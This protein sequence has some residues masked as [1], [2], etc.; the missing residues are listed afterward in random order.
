M[1]T[2]TNLAVTSSA[3]NG[4]DVILT[5]G[6]K[7]TITVK[8]T[9]GKA[10]TVDNN[11][12]QDTRVFGYF[13]VETINGSV[14]ITLSPEFPDKEIKEAVYGSF[15]TSIN[16]SQVGNGIAF[17]A[18]SSVEGTYIIGT[19]YNDNIYGANTKNDT[20][21]GGDG[22]DTL[23]GN[24]ASSG[25]YFVHSKGTDIITDY[26]FRE[27]GRQDAIILTDSA[28]LDATISGKDVVI[29]TT[30]DGI[31]TIKNA[32]D[33]LIRIADSSTDLSAISNVNAR[34]YG[35]YNYAKNDDGSDDTNTVVINSNFKEKK[36]VASS[37]A[38]DASVIDAS[39]VDK[40]ITIESGHTS[41]SVSI[42]GSIYNDKITAGSNGDTLN[43][44][45][46]TDTLVGG[47]G[48]DV[49]VHTAGNDI[50]ESYDSDADIIMLSESSLASS[51]VTGKN[52]VLTLSSGK[53]ITVKNAKD[54]VMTVV[55]ATGSDL[56]TE[57]RVFGYYNYDSETQT[58]TLNQ[59]FSEST[60]LTESQ[61]NTE[62]Q[63]ID[64]SKVGKAVKVTAG[65]TAAMTVVGS[66]YNDKL[67]AGNGQS[68][69]INGGK[70]NDAITGNTSDDTLI[71][72]E[73]ADTLEG[74]AG[75][76]TFIYVGGADVIK[77]YSYGDDQS[78]I[79]VI[80][81]GAVVSSTVRSKDVV[82]TIGKN[83]TIT[84][85][86]AKDATL[87]VVD[88]TGT[89]TR[90]FGYYGYGET[91]ETIVLNSD[92]ADKALTTDQYVAEIT[93]IDGSSL[94]KGI[95]INGN[96]KDNVITG[97]KY[98][99][100]IAGGEGADSI[101]AG[102]GNDSISGGNGDDTLI[103]GAGNDTFTGG[104]GVDRFVYVS[105]TDVITDYSNSDNDVIKLSTGKVGTSSYK[106]TDVILNVVDINNARKS[107]GTITLKGQKNQEVTVIDANDVSDTRLFGYYSYGDTTDTIIINS[108]FGGNLNSAATEGEAYYAST[109]KVINASNIKKASHIY[110]NGENI[111]TGGSGND[112]IN[113]GSGN[114]YL[115]GGA[116]NDSLIGGD[117]A[118]TLV[119]GAGNDTMYGAGGSNTF[120]ATAGNEVIADYSA[121]DGN[122]IKLSTGK[123]TA[124][125]IK[126]STDVVLTIGNKGTVTVKNANAT[127]LTVIDASGTSETR[128][129]GYYDYASATKTIT[130]NSDFKGT[131][132]SATGEGTAFY[133]ADVVNIDASKVNNAITIQGNSIA[134]KITAA[135]KSTTIVAG[136]GSNTI[137][138]G[139]A[140]DSII[141]GDGADSINAGAGNDVVSGGEGADIIDGGAGND[142]LNGDAAADTIYAGAGNDTMTGGD[143]N[144]IFVYSAGTDIITDYV[145]GSDIISVSGGTVT[146]SAVKNGNVVLTVGSKGTITVV[147]AKNQNLTV[148]TNNST[149][150]GIFGY[151]SGQGTK[152]IKINADFTGTLYAE[153]SDENAYYASNVETID[154]GQV[155]NAIAINGNSNN[156]RITAGKRN[157]T[158]D[159]GAGNDTLIGGAGADSLFGGEGA[160][161]LT[162][163]AGNDT[164]WGGAGND[165]LT[166]GAGRDVFMYSG[167]NDVITDY[168]AGQDTIRAEGATVSRSALS[169][170]DIV[171]TMSNNNTLTVKN[172]NGK[173]I[174]LTDGNGTTTQTYPTS[175]GNVAVSGRSG[176]A[177]DDRLTTSGSPKTT[178]TSPP[179]PAARSSTIFPASAIPTTALAISRASTT[180][181]SLKTPGMRRTNLFPAQNK[182]AA[183]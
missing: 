112:T 131:L 99:D 87:R 172:G 82:L 167:G 165:T 97:G 33:Q 26:T 25:N 168:V 13:D 175:N 54:K 174:T 60:G 14:S 170:S 4:E 94:T 155:K 93:T 63:V 169:G 85:K 47:T 161:I 149:V 36:F 20:L 21:N 40:G 27:S 68:A 65:S 88:S 103:G 19:N 118:D 144:D 78:D 53:T 160:D 109:V 116:G 86:N 105:G 74:K 71:G 67:Y 15:V 140:A 104:S 163:G 81:D 106:G 28:I 46:G 84:V 90:V 58:I 34:I 154:G 66:A 95:T 42:V 8:N 24:S 157:T 52:V 32:K 45:D 72:G 115:A 83:Q 138:G 176:N 56:T 37:L 147:N 62:V 120:I 107:V 121:G 64:A 123:V 111:I 108:D 51:S 148:A 39:E 101:S 125:T 122:V 183:A 89:D 164:L 98:A 77:D 153:A 177:V 18:N 59:T 35:Y 182:P 96:E 12:T 9:R 180:L 139:T 79:I 75:N 119:G 136:S 7:G 49:F 61:Y 50:I 159:G 80:S 69:Y 126:N 5:V 100:K 134:N 102:D 43:G 11:G 113:A 31:V 114:S 1:F 130:L 23:T 173:K 55:D 92:F 117:G 156:N 124:S 91:T 152:A 132:G 166:G 171:F 2:D 141:G 151:Y 29:T 6:E 143:G 70:G 128:L 57:T 38:A 158:I 41:K 48:S 44:G 73:G 17:Y 146:T 10:I 150:T 129:F 179:A 135:K 133:A 30:G 137:I 22:I 16:G 3:V 178:T 162:G 76:D 145:S 127:E 142:S 181:T 110:G